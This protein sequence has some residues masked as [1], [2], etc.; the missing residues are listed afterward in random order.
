MAIVNNLNG[1]IEG[2]NT[3]WVEELGGAMA[4]LMPRASSGLT[5]DTVAASREELRA[6]F[7]DSPNG[8]YWIMDPLTGLAELTT[9]EFG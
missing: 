5:V 4:V 7:P 3:Y 2:S 9:V 8:A 1:L 6:A